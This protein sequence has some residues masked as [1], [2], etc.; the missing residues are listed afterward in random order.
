[1]VEYRYID[2]DVEL[3]FEI[4][5]VKNYANFRKHLEGALASCG[6]SA[7]S[8]CSLSGKKTDRKLP[9]HKGSLEGM[10]KNIIDGM[11]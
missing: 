10:L 2:Y 6:N 9:V 3:K 11:E 1:M 7:T 5:G 4:S 8:E